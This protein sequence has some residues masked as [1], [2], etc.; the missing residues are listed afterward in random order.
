LINSMSSE[1]PLRISDHHQ[2]EGQCTKAKND[3]GMSYLAFQVGPRGPGEGVVC[4]DECPRGKDGGFCGAIFDLQFSPQFRSN[5]SV[6]KCFQSFNLL[7][8]EGNSPTYFDCQAAWLMWQNVQREVNVNPE[9]IHPAFGQRRRRT[10][11]MTDGSGAER[12]DIEKSH[13]AWIGYTQSER[14]SRL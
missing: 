4:P 5:S 13:P 7:H 14:H 2:G 1:I 3:R 9:R 11:G 12:F 8:L 6:A 10:T